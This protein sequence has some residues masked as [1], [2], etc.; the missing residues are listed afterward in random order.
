VLFAS[1]LQSGLGQEFSSDDL[2]ESAYAV[3]ARN[4]WH[5]AGVADGRSGGASNFGTAQ[6][7]GA[8]DSVGT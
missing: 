8:M 5:V 3:E 2:G 4:T 1:E 6:H 7:S